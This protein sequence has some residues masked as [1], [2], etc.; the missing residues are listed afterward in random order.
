MSSINPSQLIA[1]QAQAST[2]GSAPVGT[3]DGVTAFKD[4]LL[5]SIRDVNSMQQQADH[6]VETMMSGGD[7]DP[8]E[9]LTAIQKADLAFRMMMQMR[10][11]MMQVYQEVRD[12]RI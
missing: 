3:P 8:A 7:A 6:A 12:I 1:Q 10:N 5:D 4:F 2:P 11:K 9:V